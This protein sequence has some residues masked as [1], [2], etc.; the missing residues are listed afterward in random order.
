M[1]L[2]ILNES[3]GLVIYNDTGATN[4]PTQ[5][6]V[7]WR[8]TVGNVEVKNPTTKQ[9]KIPVSSSLV[10]F[11]GTRATSID[12][13]TVFS[14]SLNSTSSSLYRI[15]R[16]SG[17][18]P[19]FRTDRALALNTRSI[20]VA[21]NNNATATFTDSLG[22][23]APC[24]VGDTLFIPTAL[25]GDATSPFNVLNG[26]YWS[27]IAKTNNT[28]TAIRLSGVG[29][30][31][32]AETVAVTANSQIQA[33]SSTGVQVGDSLEISAGFSIVT[34][35]SYTVASVTPTRVEFISTEALPLESGIVPTASGIA[36]YTDC[37][38]FL[39]IEADQEV[40]VR[41][42]GDTG[43]TNRLSPR[44]SGDTN[45]VGSLQ[46]WGPVWS[47]EVVNRS[48]ANPVNVTLITCE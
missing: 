32:T 2:S 17:T 29:F 42:N 25:T 8:R 31:A 30:S 15:E 12:G 27:I 28:V 13:T 23:F 35:K 9:Y 21:V 14:I 39:R 34:Q 10:L 4:N 11:S 5:R 48:S 45:G 18:L 47:L 43:N 41:F 40:A 46:K 33:F 38:R 24:V 3:V 16:T 6:V 36:F 22:G 20:V 37:K 7:D 19:A 26:G 44:V 1:P